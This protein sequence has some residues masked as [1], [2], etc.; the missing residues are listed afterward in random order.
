MEID[1]WAL[2]CCLYQFQVS[3]LAYGVGDSTFY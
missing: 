1:L 3:W 2:G